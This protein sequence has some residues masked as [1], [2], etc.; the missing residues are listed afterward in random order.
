[1]V[2][3]ARVSA[4]SL[5]VKARVS[6]ALR[7]IRVARAWSTS[8]NSDSRWMRSVSRSAIRVW[9]ASRS[10]ASSPA[11]LS[12]G[13]DLVGAGKQMLARFAKKLFARCCPCLQRIEPHALGGQFVLVTF[14]ASSSAPARR[15]RSRA[16]LGEIALD[17]TQTAMCRG[18]GWLRFPRA[19]GT[20]EPRRR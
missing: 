13:A 14:L 15:A 20:R 3:S 16:Q 9:R 1:M 19:C 17:V 7:S 10:S 12:Y 8:V 2:S 11:R 5:A 4:A 18:Q 6:A